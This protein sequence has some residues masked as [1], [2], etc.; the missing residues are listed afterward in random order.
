[1]TKLELTSNKHMMQ[2]GMKAADVKELDECYENEKESAI[3][4]GIQ[5]RKSLKTDGLVDRHEQRQP[6]RPEVTEEIIGLEI[7]QLW[8][9]EEADGSKVPQ[10]CQDLVVAVKTK[11]RV[12]IQWTDNCLHEGDL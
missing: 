4:S 6:P 12:H 7:E 2:L 8:M 10:W 1:M 5:L 9:L 3:E 11:N